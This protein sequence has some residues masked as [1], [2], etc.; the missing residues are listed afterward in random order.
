MSAAPHAGILRLYRVLLALRREMRRSNPA[1][2]VAVSAVDDRAVA[3]A[4]GAHLVV[5][6]LAGAGTVSLETFATGAAGYAVVLTTED[7]AFGGEGCV[8]QLADNGRSKYARH[9]CCGVWRASR[10]LTSP[11]YP[12]HLQSAIF[13]TADFSLLTSNFRAKRGAKRG[14]REV[15]ACSCL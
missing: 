6:R 8:P 11:E 4:R 10:I 5:V 14:K 13:R 12:N 9:L 3:I 2:A 1:A 7:G 15:G